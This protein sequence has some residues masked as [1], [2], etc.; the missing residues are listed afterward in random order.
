RHETARRNLSLLSSYKG[1]HIRCIGRP[2]PRKAGCVVPLVIGVSPGCEEEFH[3]PEEWAGRF[4]PSLETLHA[5][6]ILAA[7]R[8][9]RMPD[10]RPRD[11]AWF[12]YASRHLERMLITGRQGI[13][14][15]NRA[16]VFRDMERL[17]GVMLK[18]VSELLGALTAASLAPRFDSFGKRIH[19]NHHQVARR[20]LAADTC[21]K[22]AVEHYQ[23]YCWKKT[24][25]G[26]DF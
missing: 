2:I 6:Y 23:N 13:S 14:G 21:L 12:E 18:R 4:M 15:K 11:E 20:W 16:V 3:I 10:P 1:L 26:S 24:V 19:E 8:E 25:G 9:N 7:K 22:H 17:K 5:A